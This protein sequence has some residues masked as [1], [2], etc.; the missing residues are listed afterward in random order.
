MQLILI[1]SC[2][3][4]FECLIEHYDITLPILNV[5]KYAGLTWS[6]L[7]IVVPTDL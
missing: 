3:T 4:I 5:T 2:D 7:Q 1:V 6:Q